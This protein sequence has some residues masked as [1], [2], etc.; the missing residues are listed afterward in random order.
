MKP[1][2]KAAR[3]SAM[4]LGLDFMA[5]FLEGMP[6]DEAADILQE[7]EPEVQEKILEQM[8]PG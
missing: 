1:I 5:P 4:R 8:V 2:R 3:K 6:K 7:H